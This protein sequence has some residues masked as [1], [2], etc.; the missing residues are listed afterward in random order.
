MP[1]TKRGM[2]RFSIL[3]LLCLICTALFCC[4]ASKALAN[5]KNK[6]GQK[7]SS[8]TNFLPGWLSRKE[9]AHCQVGVE[10]M[11]LPSGQTLLAHNN[12]CHFI[13]ASTAKVFTTACALDTL[14]PNFTYKTIFATDGSLDRHKLLGDLLI[15]SSEDP[16]LTRNDLNDLIGILQAK[17]VEHIE[18][19]VKTKPISGGMEYFYPGWLTEDWGQEWMPV[20]SDLVIDRN[21]AQAEPNFKGFKITNDTA[22]SADLALSKTLLFSDLDCDWL[23]I[24]LANGMLHINRSI[25]PKTKITSKGPLLI[26]NPDLYNPALVTQLIRDHG[27]AIASKKDLHQKQQAIILAEHTSEPLSKIITTT[28]HE[29]D[30]LYAQQILRT[31]GLKEEN[32]EKGTKEVLSLEERGSKTLEHWLATIGIEHDSV[33]LFDACGLSRKNMVTPHALNMVLKHMSGSKVNGMFLSLLKSDNNNHKHG[34]YVFKT[35]A[36]DSVR[37]IT[38]VLT[39]ISGKYFAVTIMINGN[40]PPTQ[41]LRPCLT[42]FI[43]RLKNL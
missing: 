1:S 31:L 2:R 30:N 23:S 32:E 7:R 29:S 24:D 34:T 33:F 26:A 12:N 28:L 22:G 15:Q 5:S 4:S 18:G 39:S 21:I 27:I 25:D 10:V 16:T 20:C 13:P 11:A 35:G 40:G 41:N 36:M 8:S 42:D 43:D 9:L 14:G 17:G 38:G 37:C 6:S 19:S 3:V